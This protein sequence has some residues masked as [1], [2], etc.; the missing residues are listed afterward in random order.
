MEQLYLVD[1]GINFFRE[2]DNF[3]F[4]IDETNGFQSILFDD[5]PLRISSNDSENVDEYD[6]EFYV[7]TDESDETIDI[8]GSDYIKYFNSKD[9]IKD[10]SSFNLELLNLRVVNY[11]QYFIYEEL[12]ENTLNI[13]STTDYI[14]LELFSNNKLKKD[15]W[16]FL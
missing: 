7:E 3:I 11:T 8:V 2:G 10:N 12:K 1:K 6:E 14:E 16:V 9:I 15:R 13:D 5:D 4:E